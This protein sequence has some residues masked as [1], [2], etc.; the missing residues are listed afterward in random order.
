MPATRNL[1]RTLLAA[2]SA[3]VAAE[4]PRSRDEAVIALRA[5]LKES[6]DLP[7]DLVRVLWSRL[8]ARCAGPVSVWGPLSA[9]LAAD[10]YGHSVR[11]AHDPEAAL[12]AARE[13]GR[14]VLDLGRTTP[15]WA[16]LLAQP[17][18]RVD[19]GPARRRLGPSAGAG[20]VGR[21]HRAHGRGPHLLGHRGAGRTRR[22]SPTFWPSGAWRE[23]RWRPAG[24]LKLFM[25]AGYVQPDDGRLIAPTG[26]LSGVIG[27][28][29][30]F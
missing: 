5:V 18:L 26:R 6:G 13:G 21:G 1:D 23:R 7:R 14:A 20:G 25:L 10:R 9:L 4:G 12:K 30:V 19:R 29:P 16:R 24:G 3:R 17:D 27:A 2:L 11:S 28:A 15:W 8:E 22:R